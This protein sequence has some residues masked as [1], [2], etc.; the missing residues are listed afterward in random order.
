MTRVSLCACDLEAPVRS[1]KCSHP[2]WLMV[3]ERDAHMQE[4]VWNR[5]FCMQWNENSSANNVELQQITIL[6]ARTVSGMAHQWQIL[7]HHHHRHR[8]QHLL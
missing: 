4:H 1:C 3:Q 2:S 5:L 6:M 8:H 7:H